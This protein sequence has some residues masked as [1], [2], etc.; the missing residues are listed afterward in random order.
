MFGRL[1]C[2]NCGDKLRFNRKDSTWYCNNCFY[3]ISMEEMV[4]KEYFTPSGAIKSG[5]VTRGIFAIIIIVAIFFAIFIG[6]FI[7]AI[8]VRHFVTI[9]V[10]SENYNGPVKIFIDGDEVYS[11][12]IIV[13]ETIKKTF[14]LTNGRHRFIISY[15]DENINF[16]GGIEYDEDFSYK[17]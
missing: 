7:F 5:T 9:S 8:N 10:Y 15:G 13:G 4:Q 6:A 12:E 16:I 11:E 17:I 1:R 3:S 2:P 14:S